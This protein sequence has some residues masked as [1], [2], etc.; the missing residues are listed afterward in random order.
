MAKKRREPSGP[1]PEKGYVRRFE[2][3]RD[4]VG[5]FDAY[6]FAI[7]AI[8]DLEAIELDRH[9]TIFVG[10][11]GSGKSTL[12]EAMAVAV[13]LNPEGG[14]KNF[15]FETRQSHSVLG[16][17]LQVVRGAHREQDAFFLRGESLYNVASQIDVL[18][19]EPGGAAIIESYGGRSLHK[20]SHGESFLALMKHRLGGGGIYIFD[21]PESAL[22]PSRQIAMLSIM[23]SLTTARA[24]QIVLATHSPILL[25]YPGARIYHLSED[26]MREIE[27][28]ETEHFQTTKAFLADPGAFLFRLGMGDL[29]T[30]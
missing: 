1:P 26:G 23:H 5:S 6:P 10:E 11:N 21:E 4:K 14:T 17:Y 9:V 2:L 18:D 12:I 20:Q 30:R 24:S 7:P 25:A 29:L 15:N 16:E 22:S 3:R 13:G 28:E 19:E 8:R 27:Y